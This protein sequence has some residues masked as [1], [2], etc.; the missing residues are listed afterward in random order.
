[1]VE[2][3]PELRRRFGVDPL[4]ARRLVSVGGSY[5]YGLRLD[6]IRGS[7]LRAALLASGGH[8]KRSTEGLGLVD[9]GRY[10]QVPQ[11]LLEAGVLGLGARDAFTPGFTA[12]AIS[13][14]SRAALLG[15]DGR[16]ID[17]PEYRAAAD[18]LGDVV[19]AR[20]VSERHLLSV[21]V[22][23]DLVATGVAP[24]REV[25]CVI[26]GTGERA[27]RT[28]AALRAG[29]APSA[30]DPRTGQSLSGLIEPG[31]KVA[32]S[33]YE[34]VAVVRAEVVPVKGRAG[35]FFGTIARGSLVELIR[36][37]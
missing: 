3:A 31:V 34:G 13:A 8:P 10:A 5:A 36:P 26:G 17:Q 32:T 7:G 25:L 18:C 27:R 24:D 21:E 16:L 9:A 23:I 37:R 35:F 33:S 14:T 19:A 4:A 29:L 1:M 22:G 15:H 11:P 2:A 30:R 20:L 28:A 6:G 12:L